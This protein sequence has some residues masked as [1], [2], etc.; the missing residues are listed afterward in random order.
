VTG[1]QTC[2]LPIFHVEIEVLAGDRLRQLRGDVLRRR[3]LDE[4]VRLYKGIDHAL[5][6]VRA[7]LDEFRGGYSPGEL[8]GPAD[9]LGRVLDGAVILEDETFVR[10]HVLGDEGV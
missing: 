2:A 9:E 8:I 4:A 10:G 3:R 5:H 1:V 7:L 6:D